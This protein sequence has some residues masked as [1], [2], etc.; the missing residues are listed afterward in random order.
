MNDEIS[1]DEEEIENKMEKDDIDDS[2]E[3]DRIEDEALHNDD[4]ENEDD[5]EDLN[6]EDFSGRQKNV[7]MSHEDEG[8]VQ[9]TSPKDIV[10]NKRSSDASGKKRT[11]ESMEKPCDHFDKEFNSNVVLGSD[12][13]K[14]VSYKRESRH[15][16]G[17]EIRGTCI[18]GINNDGNDENK[19]DDGSVYEASTL[20]RAKSNGTVEN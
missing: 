6:L 13:S 17:A 14:D 8:V 19:Y 4:H 10:S 3:Y 5:E 12:L 20:H 7:E 2:S 9:N 18:Q 16:V 15:T 1:N 11:F